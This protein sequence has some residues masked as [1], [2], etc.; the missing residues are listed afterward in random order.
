MA[1]IDKLLNTMELIHYIE[2][3]KGDVLILVVKGKKYIK[4]II[5]DIIILQSFN[6]KVV[7][8][9][10]YGKSIYN[11]MD[12]L[13]KENTNVIMEISSMLKKNS[14][15][16]VIS[17]GTDVFVKKENNGYG[18]NGFDNESFKWAFSENKIPIIA[19]IG[20]D[21]RGNYHRIDEKEI[22]SKL[23]KVL[24][25]KIVYFVSGIDGIKKGGKRVQ[26]LN[27]KDVK[28]L[29]Q[30]NRNSKEIKDLLKYS[31]KLMDNGTKECAILKGETGNIY[32]EVLTYDICGT[33]IKRVEEEKIRSA[34]INDISSIYL[35]MRN[36]M[37]NKNILPITED[38]IEK[39]IKKY[40]VYDIDGS[41]V[42]V[43]KLND[44]NEWAEIAKIATFPR[45]QGGEKAKKV[46]KALIDKAKKQNRRFVFGLT[47][48]KKMINLFESL[49]FKNISRDEL[50]E[51]W[52]KNYDFSRPS[53][54]FVLKL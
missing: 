47:I 21:K 38:K 1:Q 40:I 51:K 31:L 22:A 12:T 2:K 53:K 19:P 43:G 24:K 39:E 45:Y 35:L 37:K 33:F 28:K 13:I 52:K 16:P 5:P 23:A 10:G 11:K 3:F 34:K 7:L 6:I 42:A 32:K 50:P 30:N 49:G 46:C 8:V 29:L 20:M 18:I 9:L 48:N 41:V 15:K 17:L 54:A 26:F 14:L 4:E 36:E 27:Y 25:S 44:Y